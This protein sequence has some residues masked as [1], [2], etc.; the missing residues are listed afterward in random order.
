[1][2]TRYY[3]VTRSPASEF[4]S[5]LTLSEIRVRLGTGELQKAFYATESD[6]RSFDQFQRGGGSGR[7]RTLAELL[8]EPPQDAA[9]TPPGPSRWLSANFGGGVSWLLLAVGQ[10]VAVIACVAIPLGVLDQLGLL[11]EARVVVD[12][13]ARSGDPR[14]GSASSGV[15][16]AQVVVVVA[17]ILAFCMN[18]ALFVVLQRASALAQLAAD[19]DAENQ[20][21]WQ[22]IAA[23]QSS[24]ADPGAAADGGRDTG[25]S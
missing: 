9:P 15:T 17:G 2:A 13:A 10:V 11:G 3:Y 8:R 5:T 12:R 25:S 19:Q 1:M 14:A 6:G 7:W 16:A 20:Q 18:A 22:A 23:L 4:V 21:L 24:R